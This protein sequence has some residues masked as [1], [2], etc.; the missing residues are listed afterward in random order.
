MP[1]GIAP[2]LALPAFAGRPAIREGF[3]GRILAIATERPHIGI[4]PLAAGRLIT[5]NAGR[6]LQVV[7]GRLAGI[8]PDG[9]VMP[10]IPERWLTG[11]SR[12]QWLHWVAHWLIAVTIARVVAV[13]TGRTAPVTPGRRVAGVAATRRLA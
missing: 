11:V 7:L 10:I 8:V 12:R 6:G 5:P 13:V 2:S 3:R 4:L 1:P 9:R